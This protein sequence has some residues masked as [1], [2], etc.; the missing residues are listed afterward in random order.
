MRDTS[1]EKGSEHEGWVT[2]G[3]LAVLLGIDRST[4][5]RRIK[6]GKLPSHTLNTEHGWKLWSPSQVR[7]ILHN[8]VYRGARVTDST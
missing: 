4:V 2:E 6:R 8:E 3:E 5:K 7:Q 1:G